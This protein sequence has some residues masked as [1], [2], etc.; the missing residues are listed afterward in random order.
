MSTKEKNVQISVSV[1]QSVVDRAE[2][3]IEPM[4]DDMRRRGGEASRAAVFRA[5]LYEGLDLLEK[6]YLPKGDVE[7]WAPQDPADEES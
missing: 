7:G 3:L 5:A 6:Q 4:T 2:A 1:W